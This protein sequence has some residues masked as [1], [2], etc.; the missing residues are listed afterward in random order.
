MVL[1]QN[2]EEW[3]GYLMLNGPLIKA[4]AT[5]QATFFKC[6]LVAV[7]MFLNPKGSCLLNLALEKS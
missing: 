3:D 6:L 2:P 5:F 1:G 7:L 4:N